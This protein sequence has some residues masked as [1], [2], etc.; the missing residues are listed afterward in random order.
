MSVKAA[1][2]KTNVTQAKILNN[3]LPFSPILTRIISP[4]EF[5][6]CLIDANKEP[7]S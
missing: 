3:F 4:I 1:T 5:P 7:K 6:P 2:T